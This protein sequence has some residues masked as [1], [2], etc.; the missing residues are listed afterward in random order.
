MVFYFI[1]RQDFSSKAFSNCW[2]LTAIL[3]KWH[4]LSLWLSLSLLQK[5]LLKHFFDD[6]LQNC[7]SSK[8]WKCSLIYKTFYIETYLIN[9][10]KYIK[11][12]RFVVKILQRFRLTKLSSLGSTPTVFSSKKTIIIFER[13]ILFTE[14]SNNVRREKSKLNK[15]CELKLLFSKTVPEKSLKSKRHWNEKLLL[16]FGVE[17]TFYISSYF[18]H[19]AEAAAIQVLRK[20]HYRKKS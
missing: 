2:K 12:K 11:K 4:F 9:F 7:T 15:F 14:F 6:E 13:N 17:K 3:P 19:Q 18:F 20:S 5:K 16:Y 1:F 10:E 8:W